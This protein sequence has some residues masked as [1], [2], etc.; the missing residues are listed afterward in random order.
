MLR[1]LTRFGNGH[2]NSLGQSGRLLLWAT[3]WAL[4]LLASASTVNA[5][6]DAILRWNAVA[7]QAVV[8]D[9]SGTFGPAA[10]GGP[11]RSSWALAI[12]HIAMYDAVNAI[13]GSHDPYL[14]VT[15][16]TAGA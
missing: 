8:D 2:R 16:P 4:G 6:D 1:L 12:V 13:D 14:P 5:A 7:L 3:T 10:H 9:H 15:S 11:T